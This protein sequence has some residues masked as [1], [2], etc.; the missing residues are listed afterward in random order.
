MNQPPTGFERRAERDE[1]RR[2]LLSCENAANIVETRPL[3]EAK[4]KSVAK[5]LRCII[6]ASRLQCDQLDL[7]DPF[8]QDPTE[9]LDFDT[10]LRIMLDADEEGSNP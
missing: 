7:M 1:W 6:A 9:T 5:L 8:G 3:D 2:I 10:D 4:R